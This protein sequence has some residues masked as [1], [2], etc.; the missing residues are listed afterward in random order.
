MSA[1]YIAAAAAGPRQPVTLQRE[2]SLSLQR[3]CHALHLHHPAH[4]SGSVAGWNLVRG[5]VC[6]RPAERRLGE[7]RR[8]LEEAGDVLA[9]C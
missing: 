8:R 6:E 7:R 4:C 1:C 3:R 2:P 9:T 5:C